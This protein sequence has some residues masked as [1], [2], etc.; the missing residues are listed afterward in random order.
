MTLTSSEKRSSSVIRASVSCARSIA[1]KRYKPGTP[2]ELTDDV[3]TF[4]AHAWD[5][6]ARDPAE[7]TVALTV[8]EAVRGGHRFSGEPMLFGW[9]GDRG[10]VSLT[11]PFELLLAVVPDDTVE[12]LATALRGVE[13]PGVNGAPE[14][15]ERFVAAWQ[16]ER[17]ELAFEMCLYRLG[18]LQIPSAPGRARVA[19]AGDVAIATRWLAAFEADAGVKST[20]VEAAARERIGDGRL[21]LWEDEGEPVSLAARTA[22]AAGVA[23]IAPVYT[24]SEHRR[25]GYGAAVTAACTAD[26]LAR[27]A[28]EVVLFTDLA[29]PTSN[30][31][32]RAIGFRPIADRRVIRF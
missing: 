31:I 8:I 13:L 5:L 6:L 24:P 2:W 25:R 7:H 14:T 27:D 10:A 17:A 20:D 29:N 4:A 11:P 1:R 26:A 3:E 32:Y 30:S 28:T 12:E 21:W 23:R 22:T 9:H 16:P 19:D 18:E 15:V